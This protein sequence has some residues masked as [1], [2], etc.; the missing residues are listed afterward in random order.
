MKRRMTT[1]YLLALVVIVMFTS[2]EDFL[3]KYPLDT[4]NTENFY[5]TADDAVAAI[6]AAYQPLQ[7]P[8]LHNMRMWT[9]DIIAGNSEGGA[10]PVN[11][12]DG[13]ETKDQA[14]IITTT[15][16]RSG[17]DLHKGTA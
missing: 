1:K 2:C 10:D 4:V 16:N 12:S 17:L 3:E 15:H 5:Q 14:N 6:N 8:K 11:A 13:I 9:T 7:R